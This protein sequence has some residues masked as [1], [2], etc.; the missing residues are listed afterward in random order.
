MSEPGPFVA[1]LVEAAWCEARLGGT[2]AVQH[3]PPR[4]LVLGGWTQPGRGPYAVECVESRQPRAIPRVASPSVEV[5][6]RVDK[7]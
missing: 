6:V 2:W 3:G 7:P 4:P 5:A 1:A